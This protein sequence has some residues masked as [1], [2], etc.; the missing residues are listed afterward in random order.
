M[1][2]GPSS[3]IFVCTR[4]TIR[5]R[6]KTD[7]LITPLT[8]FYPQNQPTT[9]KIENNRCQADAKN[10]R[11][12]VS[13]L[14]TSGLHDFHM[15]VRATVSIC[16]VFHRPTS[17]FFGFSPIGNCFVDCCVESCIVH[18]PKHVSLFYW[19]FLLYFF[20]DYS[21]NYFLEVFLARDI[22]PKTDT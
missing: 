15:L 2:G 7:R 11:H 18:L 9:R 3:R 20:P 16:F 1:V 12:A 8:L 6:N 14:S 13:G 5:S 17:H 4:T 21:S 22:L 10:R 19:S